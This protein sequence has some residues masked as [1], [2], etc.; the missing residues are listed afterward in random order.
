MSWKANVT[1]DYHYVFMSLLYMH[2]W[3]RDDGGVSSRFLVGLKLNINKNETFNSR[4]K[5]NQLTSLIIMIPPPTHPTPHADTKKQWRPPAFLNWTNWHQKYLHPP[6]SAPHHINL[7]LF[8]FSFCQIQMF[9]SWQSASIWFDS[10]N[11]GIWCAIA[12][13]L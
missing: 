1:D 3:S 7:F 9:G 13:Q 5:K 10:F 4:K 2:I 6:P 8:F 11:S 12:E